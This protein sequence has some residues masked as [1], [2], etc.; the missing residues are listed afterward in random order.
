MGAQDLTQP[1]P[2]VGRAAVPTHLLTRRLDGPD[3]DGSAPPSGTAGGAGGVYQSQPY[4]PAPAA[5]IATLN[6]AR[7]RRL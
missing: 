7:R 6:Q 2:G 1:A 4:Q 3:D 5:T